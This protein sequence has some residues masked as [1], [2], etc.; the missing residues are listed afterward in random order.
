MNN[1]ETF[2]LALCADEWACWRYNTWI[3]SLLHDYRWVQL[4]HD[5]GKKYFLHFVA[6]VRERKNVALHNR[7]LIRNREIYDKRIQKWVLRGS[8]WEW[9]RFFR[10]LNCFSSR[11]L[12]IEQ[13]RFVL[14][15]ILS[16]VLWNMRLAVRAGILQF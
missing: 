8:N 6:L 16:F 14:P 4:K 9:N 10:K 5:W 13:R 15:D 12:W 11:S 7:C 3:N 1:R 2:H